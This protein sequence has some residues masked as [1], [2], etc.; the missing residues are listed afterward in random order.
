MYLIKSFS[1][2]CILIISIYSPYKAFVEHIPVYEDTKI[3][4]NSGESINEVFSKITTLNIV[5]K[6]FLKILIRSNNLNLIYEQD[7]VILLPR[8]T[9]QQ[10]YFTN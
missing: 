5:N 8:L 7:N 10:Y 2:I 6:L 4:I 3:D 1:F 9:I